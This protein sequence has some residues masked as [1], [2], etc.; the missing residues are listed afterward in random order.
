MNNE[1]LARCAGLKCGGKSF[2]PQR[3]M[4]TLP[5]SRRAGDGNRRKVFSPEAKNS[6]DGFI[7]NK[8]YANLEKLAGKCRAIL[9]QFGTPGSGFFPRV[10]AGGRWKIL[11]GGKSFP[12]ID[13]FW[14]AF[15][16]MALLLKI[17]KLTNKFKFLKQSEFH[18][19]NDNIAQ[20]N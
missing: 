2:H 9:E 4:R 3:R 8:S 6:S 14:I 20:I 12:K 5:G 1:I 7:Y 15:V 10:T 16:Q 17:R 18:T 13:R 11:E 19:I